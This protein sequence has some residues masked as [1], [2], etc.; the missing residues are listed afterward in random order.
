MPIWVLSVLSFFLIFFLL[1]LKSPLKH[2]LSPRKLNQ[3]LILWIYLSAQASM[4]WFT[5]PKTSP[6]A[7][8]SALFFTC[9]KQASVAEFKLTHV[10]SLPGL[11]SWV[12][13]DVFQY[14]SSLTFALKNFPVWQWPVWTLSCCLLGHMGSIDLVRIAPSEQGTLIS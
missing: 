9:P 7:P 4:D 12:T 8:T 2:L 14:S 13:R 3:I 5:P 11:H 6:V 10:S 1:Q